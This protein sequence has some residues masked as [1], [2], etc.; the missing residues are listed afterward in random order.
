MISPACKTPRRFFIRE[1]QLS[2]GADWLALGAFQTGKAAAGCISGA[3]Q[4]INT[5]RTAPGFAYFRC[6]NRGEGFIP[7]CYEGVCCP[8]GSGLSTI[9]P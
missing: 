9:W 7:W 8:N 6:A 3:V 2:P 4:G 5:E 1:E